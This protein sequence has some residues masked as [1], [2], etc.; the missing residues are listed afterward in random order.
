MAL[1]PGSPM[2]IPAPVSHFLP[3]T[4]IRRLRMLPRIGKVLVRAGQKVAVPDVIAE[5]HIN[6]HYQLLNIPRILKFSP[7]KFENYIQCQPGDRLM[8]G[9]LI[10]GPVGMSKR[11]VRATQDCKVI[12][13]GDGQILMEVSEKLYQLK[14]GFP[15]QI[16]ELITDRGAVIEATG[17]LIQAVWGNGL[18]GYGV[19]NILAEKPHHSLVAADL[20]ISLRGSIVVAGHCSDPTALELAESL[21]LRGLILASL[22]ADL[23][24]IAQTIDIPV[25]LI[26]GFGDIPFN[27]RVYKLLTSNDRREIALNAEAWQPYSGHRPE[28][29]IPMPES[30]EILTPS[31]EAEFSPEQV[32]RI[33]SS[34]ERGS[35]G[36]IIS[37]VQRLSSQGGYLGRAAEIRLRDNRTIVVPLCNLE[38]IQ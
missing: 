10:A 22:D 23:L 29:V 20:D 33:F 26:E 28:I 3:M 9:D 36:T 18:Q 31:E 11:V 25:A 34:P 27:S 12:L 17:A 38:I 5:A 8:Q 13:V 16:V 14:S 19:M 1:E 32:V 7:R 15:G 4:R 35:L 2:T 6:P 24:H 21:P 37:I 30:G